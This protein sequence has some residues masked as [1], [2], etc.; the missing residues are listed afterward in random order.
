MKARDQLVRE[1]CA[2]WPKHGNLTIAK[3]IYKAHGEIFS[4]L[5]AARS[6]VRHVRGAIGKLNRKTVR[7]KS[8]FRKPGF[9]GQP[10]IELP[11]SQAE[12]W[13]PFALETQR[14]AILSDIHIP[15]HDDVALALA[16]DEME[17]FRPDG[18]L[19][20]GDICDFFAVSRWDRDPRKV[21]LCAEINQTKQFLS[22]MRQRFQKA[23]IVWK[24]GN[25]EERWEHYLWKKAPELLNVEHFD[26][27][28]IFGLPDLG[29][30]LVRDQRFVM[31]GKL[32]ILHGHEYPKGLTNP[33]NQARGMFLR[34]LE[35]AI[36]GHGHRSS[37]HA[38]SSM[39]GHLVTCWSTGC[40]CDLN[41]AYLR[42]NK[43]NHGFAFVE[44][45]KDGSFEVRNRRIYKG[46][47]Y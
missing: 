46:K 15:Y 6:S 24:M 35:C 18:I 9:S 36:A 42:V 39:L 31:A 44:I 7:D 27:G 17:S 21:N 28:S 41:P 2:K 43:W 1:Y 13:A 38:E 16:I 29:V 3:A 12:A 10:E 11:K 4:S 23:R 40:L 8:L 20:N 5:D 26:F 45:D 47:I 32:P 33:V 30:E 19:L 14:N 34:G 25:H 22:F 37:E